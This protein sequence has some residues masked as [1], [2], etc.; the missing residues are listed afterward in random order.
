MVTRREDSQLADLGGSV[1]K[2]RRTARRNLLL[3]VAKGGSECAESMRN[4]I[5]RVLGDAAVGRAVTEDSKVSVFE[6]RDL[7]AITTESEIRAAFTRQYQLS[8][9]AVK[10]RSLR[11][12]YGE[13]K[14]AVISLPCPMANEVRKRGVVRIGW[15]RCRL[16]RRTDKAAPWLCGDGQLRMPNIL[17]ADGFVRAEVSG[18]YINSCYLAPSL[19]LEVFS[20]TLDILCN[21]MHGRPKIIVGGDFNAWWALVWRSA[22]T[23]A[24]GRTV[25]EALA[26]TNVA[27][28]KEGVRHTFDRAGAASIIDL[29]YVSSAI[30]H[31]A[32]WRVSD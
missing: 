26:S 14:T 10:V 22:S 16:G 24:R 3:E 21:D 20:R 12:G 30:F 17:A 32:R 27:L 31:D 1:N 8:E 28:L 18:Y 9:G 15:T 6:I 7:D 29:T 2:V 19:P 5:S 4:S 13:S 11:P 25:L 23:N